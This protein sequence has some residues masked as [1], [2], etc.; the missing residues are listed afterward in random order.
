MA[1]ICTLC[2]LSLAGI[3]PFLGFFGKFLLFGAV[4]EQGFIALA[5][6]AIINSAIALYY[7]VGIIRRMYLDPVKGAIP[8]LDS[9]WSVRFVLSVCGAAT[10]CLGILPQSILVAVNEFLTLSLL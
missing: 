10:L 5:L 3:P 6:V 4:I 9:A 1:A 8:S 7:Y 2:L